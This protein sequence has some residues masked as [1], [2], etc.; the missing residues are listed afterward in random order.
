MSLDNPIKLYQNPVGSGKYREL[1]WHCLGM[2]TLRRY[3]K[4]LPQCWFCSVLSHQQMG[5]ALDHYTEK[6][7]SWRVVWEWSGTGKGRKKTG[8]K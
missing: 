6:I 4:H 5:G 8:E 1:A 7:L 2:V 3:R